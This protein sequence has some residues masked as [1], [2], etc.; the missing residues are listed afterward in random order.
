MRGVFM[1]KLVFVFIAMILAGC[2]GTMPEK[3]DLNIEIGNQ[4]GGIYPASLN[5]TVLGQD[6]RPDPHIITFK[7]DK[8]P[9]TILASRIPPENLLK[10]SLAHGFRQQGLAR[11][12]RSAITAT[13]VIRELLVKVTRPGAMYAAKANTRLQFIVNNNGNILT[14]EFNRE[15]SKDTLARP[16]LLDLEMM[17]N[18]QLSEIVTKILADERVRTAINRKS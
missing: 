11:T 12:D 10:E 4:S 14:L 18:E 3:A 13:V 8:D 17:L 16:K 9:A 5:I 2:A 15:S 7:T 6:K 1:K